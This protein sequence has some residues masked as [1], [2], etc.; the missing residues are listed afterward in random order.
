MYPERHGIAEGRKK[1]WKSSDTLELHLVVNWPVLHA[2][3]KAIANP[4]LPGL[5]TAMLG[6]KQLGHATILT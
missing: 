6:S 2:R 5:T 3:L 4:S 1:Q